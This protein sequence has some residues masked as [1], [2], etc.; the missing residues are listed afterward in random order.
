[1]TLRPLIARRLY[2][3]PGYG[4]VNTRRIWAGQFLSAHWH[5]SLLG[6]YKLPTWLHSS[7]YCKGLKGE[8]LSGNRVLL[9]LVDP[10]DDTKKLGMWVGGGTSGPGVFSA[11]KSDE[12]GRVGLECS[13][14]KV[15][16]PERWQ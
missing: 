12:M 3:K 7:D 1:V 14:V 4:L 9:Y 6:G 11:I 16:V 13:F 8:Q 15:K 5:T 10:E 2:R